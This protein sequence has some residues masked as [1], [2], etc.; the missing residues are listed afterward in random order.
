MCD[1]NVFMYHLHLHSNLPR[2]GKTKLLKLQS[3][4][5]RRKIEHFCHYLENVQRELQAALCLLFQKLL[6]APASVC[7][8]SLSNRDEQEK[9]MQS[10]AAHA[11]PAG[12]RAQ[13]HN[14]VLPGTAVVQAAL[15]LLVTKARS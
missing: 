10:R 15:V 6:P 7:S 5:K 4:S 3:E 13:Q 8:F 1:V 12:S 14:V 9:G 2:R 11:G